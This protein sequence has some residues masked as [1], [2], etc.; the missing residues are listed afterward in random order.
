MSFD[1]DKSLDEDLKVAAA[2]G[3]LQSLGISHV[4]DKIF[5]EMRAFVIK[6]LL[7]AETADDRLKVQAYAACIDGLQKRLKRPKNSSA[8][9]NTAREITVT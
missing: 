4:L 8:V 1:L 5:D 7:A 6:A 2:I 9:K 3:E